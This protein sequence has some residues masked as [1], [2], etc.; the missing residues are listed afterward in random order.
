MNMLTPFLAPN[1]QH[2]PAAVLSAQT[3]TISGQGSDG[4]RPSAGLGFPA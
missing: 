4:P 1:T 2:K 3:R